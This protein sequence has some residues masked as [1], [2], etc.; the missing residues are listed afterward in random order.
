ML[1]QILDLRSQELP[2]ELEQL[3]QEVRGFLDEERSNARFKPTVDSWLGGFD[4]DFSRRVGERGWIGMTWPRE[5]GGHERS[6]LE[7]F[8]VLEEL[9]AAGAPVAAHWVADRQVGPLLLRFGSEAQRK[10]YLPQ[11]A[12]GE[13][14]FAIGMSE[15]DSGSDL[16]SLRTRA[17]REGDYWRVNGTKVWT[18]SA[19]KAQFINALVRTGEQSEDRHASLSQITI[20]LSSPGVTVRPIE[21][22]SGEH[23]FNEVTF[24]DVLVPG[25][26]VIGEVGDGWHQVTTEL[27]YERS[28]PE[29]FLSVMQLLRSFVQAHSDG[30]DSAQKLALGGLTARLWAVRQMSIAVAVGLHDGKDT[31]VPA[32]LVKDIGTTLEQEVVERLREVVTVPHGANKATEELYELLNFAVTHSPG[33]T[34]RGGTSE[35]LRT[36]IARGLEL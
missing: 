2:K 1:Q 30:L 36:I 5:Y 15:P 10:R 34:L 24:E 23:H 8:V 3:R 7:R 9:L 19:H 16:A 14:C 21:L 29:R 32:A 26:A 4:F 31:E 33:F 20:D 22:L 25:E 13:C 18:T 6:S 27:A 11:I 28:G 12:A 17:V 35:I